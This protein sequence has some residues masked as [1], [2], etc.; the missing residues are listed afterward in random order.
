[1]I[2]R[3]LCQILMHLF[4]SEVRVLNAERIPDQGPVLIVS[5]HHSALIDP[6]VLIAR[7]SR[8]PRFLAKAA[9][10]QARYLP[11]RPFLA[12]AR[13]V[14]VHRV[15][16]GGGSNDNMFRSTRSVLHEGGIIAL[17][18]EGIS[19][20]NP[21]LAEMKTGAARIALGTPATIPVIPVGIVY[22]DR[23]TYRSTVTIIVGEP[24]IVTGTAGGDSDRDAVRKLTQRLTRGLAEVAPTWESQEDQ[25]AAVVAAEIGATQFNQ[26][27]GA[28]LNTLNRAADLRD[29]RALLALTAARDL[30]DE[31]EHLGV[32]VT[33]VSDLPAP[34]LQR[35]VRFAYLRLAF[36]ALP[37]V[38][39][40]ILNLP[41]FELTGKL[42]DRRDLNF[43][44]TSKVLLALFIYPAW[45]LLLAGVVLWA[46][47]PLLALTTL[48]GVP[49][50]A[51]ISALRMHRLRR[52]TGRR[53]S[54]DASNE[55]MSILQS[56]H[57]TVTAA[58][59]S[60][61]GKTPAPSS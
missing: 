35:T 3:A 14:P 9:L 42:S 19:H 17:F 55:Q 31:C 46:T 7:L 36:W 38:L 1:M 5:N 4:F 48:I 2:I 39:G 59:A 32:S 56:R 61:L 20:D 12:L 43:Q 34:E 41:A 15:K 49:V 54:D 22:P 16:D 57:A 58:M 47:G 26:D 51:Y 25:I 27:R 52:L 40:K 53:L 13:A 60:V 24:V 18:G 29:P 33:T 23:T 37:A 45:W 10:W 50:T 8:Q 28:A 30:L 21:G 6:A 44:A 11:L